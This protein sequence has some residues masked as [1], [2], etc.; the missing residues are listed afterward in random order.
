MFTF[1]LSCSHCH[2]SFKLSYLLTLTVEFT[3]FKLSFSIT[4]TYSTLT[5]LLISTVI[6]IFLFTFYHCH[7]HCGMTTVHTT[8]WFVVNCY[9]AW[10]LCGIERFFFSETFF[11]MQWS[12]LLCTVWISCVSDG[13]NSCCST[14][15]IFVTALTTTTAIILLTFCMSLFF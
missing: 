15:W 12:W 6:L 11:G 10:W 3:P 13:N 14:V 7:I 4:I 2:T 1:L 5:F 9:R 8:D